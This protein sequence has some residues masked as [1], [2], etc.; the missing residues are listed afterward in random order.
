VRAFAFGENAPTS[1]HQGFTE[2][3]GVR[4]HPHIFG[5]QALRGC[6]YTAQ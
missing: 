1:L 2:A 4:C 6:G 3:R 5:W